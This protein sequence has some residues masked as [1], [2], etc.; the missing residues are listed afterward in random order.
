MRH[1]HQLAD[2]L[3]V[4]A[5]DVPAARAARQGELDVVRRRFGVVLDGEAVLEVAVRL[6]HVVAGV[7]V[8]ANREVGD[9]EQIAELDAGQDGRASR[10][11]A[12]EAPIGSA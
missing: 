11:P 1:L 6:V 9:D 5:H 10:A 4:D 12:L 3:Q 2:R 7:D 8:R